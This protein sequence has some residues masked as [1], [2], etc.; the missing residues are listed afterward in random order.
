MVIKTLVRTLRALLRRRCPFVLCCVVL[1]CCVA[2]SFLSF[3]PIT[4][5]RRSICPFS[6]IL[7]HSLFLENFVWLENNAV[8]ARTVSPSGNDVNCW[9]DRK[10]PCATI[11]GALTAS[12]GWFHRGVPVSVNGASTLVI[13][14]SGPVEL[15]PIQ[16]GAM[17][18]QRKIVIRGDGS[19]SSYLYCSPGSG[20]S[21]VM[22]DVCGSTG[23]LLLK[24]L[25]IRNC[26]AAV[27]RLLSTSARMVNVTVANI[28]T[29][30]SGALARLSRS[31]SIVARHVTATNV[32]SGNDGGVFHAV[33]SDVSIQHSIFADVDTAGA[34]GVVF[35]SATLSCS[36]SLV[37]CTRL[38]AATEVLDSRFVGCSANRGGV[39]AV[40]NTRLSVDQARFVN[41][42]AST[43]GGALSLA[44]AAIVNLSDCGA[45][46]TQAQ[47]GGFAYGDAALSLTLQR[48]S[49]V[50]R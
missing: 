41:C 7:G 29:Q 19:P 32:S 50:R 26:G 15:R 16:L 4:V 49:F 12:E 24:D 35:S 44:G 21:E 22:M 6:D 39:F 11:D 43:T 2:P 28:T 20:G 46:D 37:L 10:L 33:D 30:G 40:S 31:S 3:E 47:H 27:M 9:H 48:S 38:S 14:M 45:F 25:T 13:H 5:P 17:L 8:L 42:S 18:M 36:G 1:S 23:S 34:G